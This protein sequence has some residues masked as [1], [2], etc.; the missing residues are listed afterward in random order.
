MRK[1][2]KTLLLLLA[3]IISIATQAQTV[4]EVKS[5]NLS[6]EGTSNIHDWTADVQNVKGSFNL[7]VE[8]KKIVGIENLK[9][10]I[11]AQ[12][13]KGSKG[14][15]MDSKI[16]DALSSKK[17][18][19]ITFDLQKVNSITENAGSFTVNTTG[20]LK[21]SG[22]SKTVN[23]SASGKVN[24]NGE[25]EFAGR[26]KLKMS[27]FSVKPPT[28]MFGA[29]TTGDE[30]TLNYNVVVKPSMLSEK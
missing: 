16:N 29:L 8:N 15:I 19:E 17:H 14:S 24:S 3:I 12:S 6:I 4:Y 30:I 23:L 11:D 27:E 1:V 21:I 13:L 5:H 9:V 10:N 18:P 20:I 26:T 28:A 22:V 25:V 7:K 2:S